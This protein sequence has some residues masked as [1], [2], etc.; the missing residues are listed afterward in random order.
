MSLVDITSWCPIQPVAAITT[1]VAINKTYD[2]STLLGDSSYDVSAFT[3]NLTCTDTSFYYKF[4]CQD[5][6]IAPYFMSL[7]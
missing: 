4:Y 3:I 2:V 7:N 6:T 1:P 5:G